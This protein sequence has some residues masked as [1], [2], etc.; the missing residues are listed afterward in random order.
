MIENRPYRLCQQEKNESNEVKKE[1]KTERSKNTRNSIKGEI[2][3][4]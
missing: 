2:M 3:N 4:K 1:R